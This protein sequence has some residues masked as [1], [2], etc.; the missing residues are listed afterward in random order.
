MGKNMESYDDGYGMQIVN[1]N[2]DYIPILHD[3]LNWS[4]VD[5]DA[6]Y[7]LC[8]VCELSLA[9]DTQICSTCTYVRSFLDDD[10]NVDN[11]NL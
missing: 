4:M 6:P 2:E 11:S 1:E 5:I 8:C 10:N 9:Q 3:S 7:H